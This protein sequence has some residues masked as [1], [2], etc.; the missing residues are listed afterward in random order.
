VA[1]NKLRPHRQSRKAAHRLKLNRVTLC[2]A[3]SVNVEATIAALAAC[4]DQIEFA[5]CVLL[6]DAAVD[7]A[8]EGIRVAPIAPLLSSR[9]Y[10]NY[11]LTRLVDQVHTS[12][13]LIV[14]WD[15]FV[16]DAA[17]W[18]DRFLDFDYIGAPWPQ[19]EEHVVG[20]GGFSLRSRKLLAAC[21]DPAF[22]RGH[23]E[24]LAICRTNRSLLE[25]KFGIRIADPVSAGRFAFEREGE[26]R[27]T[28][29]FHGVFNMVGAVGPERFWQ[30]F[31]T[32]DDLSTA[33]VDYRA[34]MAQI[35]QGNQPWRRRFELT[36]KYV[37]HVLRDLVPDRALGMSDH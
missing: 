23:P 9:D 7:D 36:A 17:R 18:E 12:H 14:Q 32:L 27:A 26:D 15:G 24:D 35:G 19:F 25:E 28:F 4:L 5:D 33:F 13:C 29:G 31:S 16:L 34:L 37:R 8:H 6:T 22:V 3:T 30:L 20:N 11:I 2:A 10:S 21:R 1:S